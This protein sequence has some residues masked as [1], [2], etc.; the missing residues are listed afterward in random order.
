MEKFLIKTKRLGLRFITE[1]DYKFLKTIEK[2]Q[3]VKK[4]FAEDTLTDEEIKES[5]EDC[6]KSCEQ[7]KLPCFVIFN[8]K[9][10][11]FVG[12]AFFGQLTTGETKIA[13]LFH[14]RHWDKGYATEAVSALL[15]WAKEHID[16]EYIFAYADEANKGSLNVMEKCG[17]EYY[18]TAPSESSSSNSIYYRIKNH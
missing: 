18:K 3:Q 16:A 17:M 9:S 11:E 14:K 6:L 7:K 5:I 13:Y 10:N 15:D 1:E 12:E 8:R 4:Y 2:D